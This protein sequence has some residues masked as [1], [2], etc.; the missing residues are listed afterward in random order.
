M[1][2]EGKTPYDFRLNKESLERMCLTSYAAA[3]QKTGMYRDYEKYLPQWNVPVELEFS[4]RQIKPKD[5]LWASIYLWQCAFFERITK[6]SEIMINAHRAWYN[7]NEKWIF[8]PFRIAIASEKDVEKVLKGT[9]QF[10][11]QGKNEVSPA[12]RYKNN[13][14]LL[15]KEYDGDPRNLINYKTIE[16]SRKHLMRFEGIGTGIANLFLHYLGDRQLA[17]PI[18]PQN[19]LLK[20]DIHKG[21]LPINVGAVTPINGEIARSDK[22]VGTM[23]HAYHR[24]CKKNNLDP[25]KLDAALWLIGSLGCAKNELAFCHLKCPLYSTCLGNTSENQ[26]TGRYEVLIGGKRVDTR[27]GKGQTFLFSSEHI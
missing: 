10:N 16:E 25:K 9:F 21:R 1:N 24:I 6:S 23:E 3:E 4:P 8:D 17:V 13:A 11:L 15:L 26:N 20:V 14:S 18:D 5:E 2:K 12:I 7:P 27:K 19:G 22:Y